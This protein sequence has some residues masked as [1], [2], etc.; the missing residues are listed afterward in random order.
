MGS[1]RAFCFVTTPLVSTY[2]HR[3]RNHIQRWAQRHTSWCKSQLQHLGQ[4]TFC[5]ALMA[6]RV[7]SHR[8]DALD[9]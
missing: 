8:R 3:P 9:A 1:V 2:T 6:T 7:L 5:I 4:M